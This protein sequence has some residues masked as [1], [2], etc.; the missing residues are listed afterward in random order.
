MLSFNIN[1]GRWWNL[2]NIIRSSNRTKKGPKL[3]KEETWNC[4]DKIEQKLR[5]IE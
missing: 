1:N 5:N 2:E 3:N 4:V